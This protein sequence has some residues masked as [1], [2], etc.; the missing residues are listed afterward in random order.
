M[1]PAPQ[2]NQ[3]DLYWCEPDPKDTVGSEQEHDRPWVIVSI[4]RLQR[5]NCVVGLPLS[6]QVQKACA[7]L[8]QIPKNEITMDGGIPPYDSVALVDQ[9][10]ALD[11]TRLRRKTGRVSRR[12]LNAIFLGLDYLF[13]R[14]AL[15]K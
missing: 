12:A 2:I 4:A 14:E 3:G 5:G 7:H 10:R 11:K 6:K 15:P 9:I 13:G 8:V 1:P